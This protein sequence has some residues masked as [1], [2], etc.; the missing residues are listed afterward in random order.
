MWLG[1]QDSLTGGL[2]VGGDDSFEMAVTNLIP[3]RSRPLVATMLLVR[4][5]L[6]TCA[7]RVQAATA[8]G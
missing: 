8:A 5:T 1:R 4:L 6:C 3:E 2:L 7:H